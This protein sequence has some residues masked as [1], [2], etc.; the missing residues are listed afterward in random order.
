MLERAVRRLAVIAAVCVGA[1]AFAMYWLVS[2]P[3][4]GGTIQDYRSYAL[5][6]QTIGSTSIVPGIASGVGA[7]L[8]ALQAKRMRWLWL[9]VLSVVVAGYEGSLSYLILLALVSRDTGPSYAQYNGLFQ[10]LSF[11]VFPALP[12]LAA[13]AY[14]F[15]YRERRDARQAPALTTGD[16]SFEL[17]ISAIDKQA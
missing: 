8:L 14:S 5:V 3:S 7:A 10:A 16:E 15:R 12:V 11:F 1:S 2:H 6:L 13:L 17:T 4:Q 9:L